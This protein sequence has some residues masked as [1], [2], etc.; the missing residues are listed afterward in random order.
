MTLTGFKTWRTRAIQ[1]TTRV[2]ALLLITGTWLVSPAVNASAAGEIDE[3]L[4]RSE[5]PAGVVF[6]LIDADSDYLVEA[7]P[8]LKNYIRDLR[9]RFEALPVAIVSHGPELFALA[10]ARR[11]AFPEVHQMVQSLTGEEDVPVHVCGTFAG[12]RGLTPEDF[13]DYVDVAVTGPAQIN[14]YKAIGYVLVKLN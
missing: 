12:W 9:S 1:W 3:I 4:K 5:A 11:E 10:D 8:R 14:D 2:G 13:P 7:L 6:E